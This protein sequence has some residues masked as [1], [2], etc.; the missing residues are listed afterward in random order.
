MNDLFMRL[1]FQTEFQESLIT[2]RLHVGRG[3]AD[4]M[5]VDYVTVLFQADQPILQVGAYLQHS[6]E[7]DF[8]SWA[9]LWHGWM[10]LGFGNSIAFVNLE[11]HQTRLHDLADSFGSASYFMM[12]ERSEDYLIGVTSCGLLRFHTNSDIIWAA[13]DVGVDGVFIDKIERNTI[14]GAGKW[15]VLLGWDPFEMDLATGRLILS[16]KPPE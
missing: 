4:C 2:P 15:S 16:N 7:F 5:Q 6:R 13:D 1:D 14:F 10:V 8:T 12:I 11:T 9:E 3:Y